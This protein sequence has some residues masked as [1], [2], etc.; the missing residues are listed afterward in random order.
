MITVAYSDRS[1]D[2]DMKIGDIENFTVVNKETNCIYCACQKV[3]ETS[4][5][6]G[7]IMVFDN[8]DVT[9]NNILRRTTIEEIF[10]YDKYYIYSCGSICIHANASVSY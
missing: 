7:F 5:R 8:G 10:N 1:V 2:K 9:Y 3:S 6:K 4:D